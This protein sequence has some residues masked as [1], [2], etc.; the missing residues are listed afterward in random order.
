MY[1]VRFVSPP[2]GRQKVFF[3]HKRY[4]D[5]GAIHIGCEFSLNRILAH[6]VVADDPVDEIAF[7]CE[8][9]EIIV[10]KKT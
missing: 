2:Q 10:D 8:C 4:W 9:V 5:A 1:R 6:H 7:P 3:V